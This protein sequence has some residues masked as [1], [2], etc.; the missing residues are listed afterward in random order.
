[1][2]S[3]EFDRDDQQEAQRLF[4]NFRLHFGEGYTTIPVTMTEFDEES[5]D[6]N[7]TAACTILYQIL[8]SLT[9]AMKRKG[10]YPPLTFK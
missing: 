9:E 1:M 2:H 7:W 10:D 8:A 6:K 3:I 4:Y 5:M